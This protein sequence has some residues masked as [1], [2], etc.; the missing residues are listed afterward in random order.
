VDIRLADS[1]LGRRRFTATFRNQSVS[2]V[3]ALLGLSLELEVNRSGRAVT[4]RPRR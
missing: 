3:L 4:L 2:Q 1:S